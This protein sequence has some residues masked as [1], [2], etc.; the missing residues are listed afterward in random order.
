MKTKTLMSAGS[1]GSDSVCRVPPNGIT[2]ERSEEGIPLYPD[3][4]QRALLL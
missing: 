1:S 2:D 4:R 3:Q